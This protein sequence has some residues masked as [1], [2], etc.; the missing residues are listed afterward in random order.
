MNSKLVCRMRIGERE[1]GMNWREHEFVYII[2]M[3]YDKSANS[4]CHQQQQPNT[5][6]IHSLALSEQPNDMRKTKSKVIKRV[7]PT[8][9]NN[10]IRMEM[11]TNS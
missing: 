11:E 7:V 8:K 9:D 3:V 4:N 5:F 6:W 1:F 10:N 2:V